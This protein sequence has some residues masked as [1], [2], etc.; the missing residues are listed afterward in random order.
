MVE[1]LPAES[2]GGRWA[3]ELSSYTIFKLCTKTTKD[4]RGLPT[5]YRRKR[6]EI[7]PCKE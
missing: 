2:A 6:R 5:S 4:R 1:R 3:D 7:P